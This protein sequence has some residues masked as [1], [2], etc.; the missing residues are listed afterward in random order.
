MS[1]APTLEQ[2]RARLKEL[3]Y[4]DAG[5]ERLLFR[6]VFQGRGGAFLPAILIGSFAAALAAVAAVEAAEPAFGGSL[7]AVAALFLHVFLADLVPAALAAYVL[8]RVA[9]HA[10][11]PGLAATVAGLAAA[12]LVFGLWIAGTYGLAREL[13]ARALLWAVPVAVAA[14]FLA[15]AVRLAFLARAFARSGALP[16]RAERRAFATAAAVGLLVAIL[17]FYSRR[18]P[19]PAPAPQ[20][21][22][23]SIPVVVV[24]VDGLDL[25]GSGK[26]PAVAQLLSAGAIGWWPAE[27][28]SP[29]EIWT[30]LATGVSSGRHGVRALA[31][32]RPLGSPVALRPPF[33]T[34]WYLRRIGPPLHLVS[35][36][37]VSGADRRRLDFWEVAASAGIPS[38]AVGWWASAPWPGSTVVENRA[39]FARS[40]DGVDADRVAMILFEESA[41]RGY[42][43]ETV[44]LPGC[45]ISRGEPGARQSAAAAVEKFLSEWIERAARGECALV[46]LA[47]DSHPTAGALGRMVVFDQGAARRTV[48]ILPADV[49]PSILARAGVPAARDLEGRPVPVLFASRSLEPAT[50]ATYG[51]RAVAPSPAPVQSDREYLDKLRSLGYLK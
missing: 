8:A 18:E 5:V 6:P 42:G 1:A 26:P 33:G 40:R 38:L 36:S 2:A 13:S 11:P 34:S 27:R 28:L 51:P 45:D 21:S 17:L 19:L 35:N 16:G 29:P 31:R 9:D 7:T 25:D 4:L 3:G 12:A 32:V 24:A 48:R 10:R 30:N 43:V 22:P 39:V 50:V 20:P 23:R 41:R 44:Y 49:S 14:L 37:P 47:A 46:V 15:T